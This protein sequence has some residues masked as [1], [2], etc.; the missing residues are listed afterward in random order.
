MQL[1]V[2]EVIVPL[3]LCNNT[4]DIVWA[5]EKIFVQHSE[6][7]QRAHYCINIKVFHLPLTRQQE[8]KALARLENIWDEIINP[9]IADF[10][11][12]TGHQIYTEGRSGGYMFVDQ[13]GEV[14]DGDED[15]EDLRGRLEILLK[16]HQEWQALLK[17]IKAYLN[18]MRMP[19]DDD[20]Y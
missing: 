16:F 12:E 13:V 7:F 4:N 8:M 19:K 17:D 3:A 10:K 9:W 6:R 18:Q 15:P 14:L 2:D 11:V 5:L 20:S 1:P